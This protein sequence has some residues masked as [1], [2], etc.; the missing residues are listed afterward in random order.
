MS[1]NLTE[2]LENLENEIIEQIKDEQITNDNEMRDYIHEE[3]DN[4]CI[5]NSECLDII[6]ALNAY[7]F[8]AYEFECT[9]LAQ[10]AYCALLEETYNIDFDE[11]KN[12]END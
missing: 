10:V 9:N 8:T 6:D 7:D 1:F 4:A 11:L 3:V 5:Y 2:W 12:R